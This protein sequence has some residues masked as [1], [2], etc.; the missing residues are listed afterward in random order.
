MAEILMYAKRCKVGA[1]VLQNQNNALA[2]SHNET[3]AR[4]VLLLI[5]IFKTAPKNIV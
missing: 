5:H 3:Y 2:T 4:I 1:Y